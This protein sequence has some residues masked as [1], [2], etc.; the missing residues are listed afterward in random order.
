MV[1]AAAIETPPG[2]APGRFA[3]QTRPPDLRGSQEVRAQPASAADAASA[4]QLAAGVTMP[5]LAISDEQRVLFR[6]F[7]IHR[8]SY[9]NLDQGSAAAARV[10]GA[11]SSRRP[12]SLRHATSHLQS[13]REAEHHQGAREPEH[14][15]GAREANHKITKKLKGGELSHLLNRH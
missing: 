5:T 2:S 7:E 4:A 1:S 8:N 6:D 12:P 13:P 11:T 15:Q 9:T 10:F 14:H 3:D